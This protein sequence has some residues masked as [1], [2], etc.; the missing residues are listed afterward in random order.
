M[1]IKHEHILLLSLYIPVSYPTSLPLSKAVRDRELTFI[2]APVYWGIE[3]RA[4]IS[5][6]MEL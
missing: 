6:K 5:V 1:E 2:Q 4:G 3:F